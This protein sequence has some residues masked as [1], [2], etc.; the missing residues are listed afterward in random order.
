M[1]TPSFNFGEEEGVFE[2]VTGVIERGESVGVYKYIIPFRFSPDKSYFIFTYLQDS[3]LYSS[4]Y[5]LGHMQLRLL[6]MG[7][8]RYFFNFLIIYFCMFSFGAIDF[9]QET[10]GSYLASRR[11]CNRFLRAC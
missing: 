7:R 9:Q 8:S 1:K 11:Y 10:I 4:E 2:K 3:Q 6:S 5:L